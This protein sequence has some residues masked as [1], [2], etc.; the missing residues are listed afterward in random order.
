[1]LDLG[2]R[3]VGHV[4]TQ[5]ADVERKAPRVTRIGRQPVELLYEHVAAPRAP[6]T[7]ALELE[8]DPPVGGPDITDADR[9]LVVAAAAPMAAARALSRFFRRRRRT[10]RAMWSPN[11]PLR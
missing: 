3:L 10:T 1:M 6:H 7:P 2:H 8:V 4:T 9:T 11:T 5:P